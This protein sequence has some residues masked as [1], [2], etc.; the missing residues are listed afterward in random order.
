MILIYFINTDIINNN[1]NIKPY[2]TEELNRFIGD[3]VSMKIDEKES[4]KKSKSSSDTLKDLNYPL[5]KLL[6]RHHIFGN[7]DTKILPETSILDEYLAREKGLDRKNIISYSIINNKMYQ[8]F[9]DTAKM[10]QPYLKN[11]G[12]NKNDDN[13]D[14]NETVQCTM[15]LFESYEK[16]VAFFTQG[17]AGFKDLS[18]DYQSRIIKRNLMDF[19]FVLCL[20]YYENGELNVFLENGIQTS[21]NLLTK[22]RG[23]FIIDLQYQALDSLH[24]LKLTEREKVALIAFVF[25][26]PGI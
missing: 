14:F 19:I 20:N 8:T 26:L 13:T 1:D 5:P 7:L 17:I 16:M 23:K 25:F 4:S 2:L 15:K 3:F 21:R 12:K 9:L 10:F 11:S 18:L 6:R 22:L 24:N